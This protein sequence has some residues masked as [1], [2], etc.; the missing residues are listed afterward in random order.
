MPGDDPE[1]ANYVEVR[2]AD[3][4]TSA[5]TGPRLVEGGRVCVRGWLRVTGWGAFLTEDRD[6]II[7]AFM[8]GRLV[9]HALRNAAFRSEEIG[10]LFG[11]T[12]AYEGHAIIK[13]RWKSNSGL[14]CQ[15]VILF[16]LHE[17]EFTMRPGNPPNGRTYNPVHVA[18]PASPPSIPETVRGECLEDS[19]LGRRLIRFDDDVLPS[20][21]IDQMMHI[22]TIYEFAVAVHKEVRRR[23]LEQVAEP[24]NEEFVA[25]VRLLTE[26]I[27]GD[28]RF[29]LDS[30]RRHGI[31]PHPHL[32]LAA[33]E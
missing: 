8:P 18:F 4:W 32:R 21:V 33:L 12:V 10:M 2:L 19:G 1:S 11:A 22:A 14:N 24:I 13:G 28:L 3:L 7:H 26:L 5:T 16:G 29:Y 25:E 20:L 31:E 15:P 30:C 23:W 27:E 9:F 6:S 17:M